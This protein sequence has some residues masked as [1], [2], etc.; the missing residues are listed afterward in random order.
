MTKTLT[1]VNDAVL[2]EIRDEQH[3]RRTDELFLLF[4]LG[5]QFDHLIKLALERIGVYC[6]VA[7]PASITADDV[8]RLAPKGVV[9]SGG[10]ASVYE[11]PPPFDSRIFDLQ[12]P[13]LGICLGFQLWARHVGIQ[14]VPADKREFGT[15]EFTVTKRGLLFAGL[16]SAMPVLESHGDRIEP[17]PFFDVLGHTDHAPAAAAFCGHLYGVQF[18]PEVTETIYGLR[19][20]ENFC[21]GICGARDRFQAADVVQE[22]I[23]HLTEVI[24]GKRVLLALSGGSDS[25][26]VAYLL[27]TWYALDR[28]SGPVG[29]A[30]IRGVD[31]PDDEAHVCRYFSDQ[32]WL[33]LQIVNATGAFLE[34]LHGKLT[35]HEKR[36]A[37]REVY[38]QVL[39]EQ[40]RRFGA[41]FIA[42]GTLYTDI[43]ESGGGYQSGAAKAQIKLHHNVGLGFS[44]PELTPLADQ[45]KDTA[46]AIGRAIG[47]PEALLVRH[48]FPGPG[49]AVRIEGEVTAEKLD[50][51]RQ[52]DQIYLEE[53]RAAGLYET[54][55]QAGATLLNSETTCTKGDDAVT[56][57]VLALWAVHSVNG[58]TA[59]AVELPLG[60]LPRVSR[61]LT[62]EIRSI[63]RVLYNYSDKPPATIEWG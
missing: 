12:I 53:L 20:L 3:R 44:V 57:S 55:W 31:R 36:L 16:S 41:D 61:R 26:V 50:V 43:S 52:A 42:Q 11:A 30:Y 51:V 45:V 23:R 24:D 1:A 62:N 6:L 14:I 35:M 9:L 58:F 47:V 15:H 29:A 4:A 17:G 33:S 5:S 56:G 21:F 54:I 60:F 13:V 2:E 46:R 8:R 38:R 32:P 37:V 25:S 19:I 48:P 39:E 27:R 34:A 22:K 40:V 49:L 18:H 28:R 63:G 10:P 7:D 59:R